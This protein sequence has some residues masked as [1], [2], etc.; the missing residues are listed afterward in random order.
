M[1]AK[2]LPLAKPQ[3]SAPA[4]KGDEEIESSAGSSC[5]QTPNE[6]WPK[7]VDLEWRD[8]IIAQYIPLVN[9]I[10]NRL[11]LRLPSHIFKDDMI[12]SGIIGLIDAIHKFDPRK[13]IEFKTYAE[14]RIKGAILDELRSLDWIPRSVRKKQHLLGKTCKELQKTLGRPAEPEEVAEN[15]GIEMKEFHEML[16]ITK[17][18]SLLDIEGFWRL[19]PYDKSDRTG[20]SD[21]NKGECPI[22]ALH[23]FQLQNIVAQCIK[24]FPYGMQLMLSLYFYEE[25]TMREISLLAGCTE[26]RISQLLTEALRKTKPELAK[27]LEISNYTS[28]IRVDRHRDHPR[29]KSLLSLPKTLT[30]SPEKPEKDDPREKGAPNRWKNFGRKIYV[31]D[32]TLIGEPYTVDFEKPYTPI[33]LL[34]TRAEIFQKE[35]NLMDKD[36][37]K[38]THLL[39]YHFARKLLDKNIDETSDLLKLS[40]LQ[41]EELLFKPRT[42]WTIAEKI[43]EAGYSFSDGEEATRKL[44]S[45]YPKKKEQKKEGVQPSA[46]AAVHKPAALASPPQEPS[47]ETTSADDP[48][49]ERSLRA[50]LKRFSAAFDFLTLNGGS[51][52]KIE[53]YQEN[54]VAENGQKYILSI[55][56]TR[57]DLPV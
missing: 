49:P 43:L 34:E 1:S 19:S 50:T 21:Q 52:A 25:L 31:P 29:D 7:I 3:E 56:I 28:V 51:P 39:G 41:F 47:A 5:K 30:W 36:L 4:K 26:S 38:I 44:L 15:L 57:K 23:L 11:V 14:F 42:I 20:T 45:D 10:T 27:R 54:F 18:L 6:K 40:S 37:P 8:K 12:S 53:G 32:F 13:G 48:A 33:L 17:S 46:F 55:T 24:E 2:I 22:Q 16:D 9:Y 35:D